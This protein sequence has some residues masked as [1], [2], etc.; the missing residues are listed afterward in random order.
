MPF[1]TFFLGEGSPTKIDYRR[2]GTLILSSLLE[3][4]VQQRAKLSF[5]SRKREDVGP[6][7]ASQC[8]PLQVAKKRLESP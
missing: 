4:L 7:L 5:T 3:G 6:K 8:Q 1:L 2:K